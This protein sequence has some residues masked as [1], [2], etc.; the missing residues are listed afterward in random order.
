[1]SLV[2]PGSA[3][4][5]GLPAEGD[6]GTGLCSSSDVT[7]PFDNPPFGAPTGRRGSAKAVWL[8][9]QEE[10]ASDR[11]AGSGGEE[12]GHPSLGQ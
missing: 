7:H 11:E 6:A 4:R 8:R 3:N 12:Q 9:C 5:T 10:R 1:L 2:Y